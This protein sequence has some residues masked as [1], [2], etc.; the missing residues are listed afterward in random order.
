MDEVVLYRSASAV[1]VQN[2]KLFAG[3]LETAVI[4]KCSHAL[5]NVDI[6]IVGNLREPN[7]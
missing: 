7:T 2:T 4:Q 6:L 5:A 3:S 1:V